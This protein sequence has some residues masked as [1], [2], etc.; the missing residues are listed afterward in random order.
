MAAKPAGTKAPEII[1]Q[2]LAKALAHPTRIRILVELN[3][4][5]MSPNEF[6]QEF[7][8]SLSKVSYHFRK[9]E[10]HGCLELVKEVPRRGAV[11]HYYRGTR[12]AL[13]DDANWHSLPEA[14]KNSVTGTVF[15]TYLE[16]VVQAMRAG[17]LDAREDRHFSWTALVLDGQAWDELIEGLDA[18]FARALDLQVEAGLRMAESGEEPITATVGLAG[19]ESPRSEDGQH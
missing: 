4:R 18:L 7:D 15:Q 19:F 11:E 6:A 17:T 12:R 2:G 8:G 9:L 16:R 5:M 3:Q 14:I 1:D 13:F 10:E